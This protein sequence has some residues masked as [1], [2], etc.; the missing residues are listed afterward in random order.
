M[1]FA[2]ALVVTISLIAALASCAPSP[3]PTRDPAHQM[4]MID[5]ATVPTEF[6]GIY[7]YTRLTVNGS[8]PYLFLIDTGCTGSVVDRGVADALRLRT[9]T[10]RLGDGA[11][12]PYAV[13]V[14]LENQGLSFAPDRLDI[15]PLDSALSGALG[16]RVQ[17]ILGADF[18]A[19]RTVELDYQSG[20]V[21]ARSAAGFEASPQDA[22]LPLLMVNA[23]SPWVAVELAPPGQ[24]SFGTL[25]LVDTGFGGGLSLAAGTAR[26]FGLPGA[27]P[28]LTTRSRDVFGEHQ[29]LAFRLAGGA[30]GPFRFDGPTVTIRSAPE[31]TNPLV[32][33]S[34]IGVEVWRRFTVTFDFARCR[35]LLRPNTA[36]ADP[37]DETLTGLG[38]FWEGP[39]LDRCVVRETLEGSPAAAAGLN[40]G[41]VIIEVDGRPSSEFRA[42][43]MRRYYQSSAGRPVILRIIRDGREL[44]CTIVPARRI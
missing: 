14:Q 27:M 37:F 15:L 1:L 44:T 40:P 43:R 42:A 28:T 11:R 5:W 26:R 20:V 9:K 16:R 13:G 30:V 34:L 3:P 8:G 25:L 35:L 22:V 29:D 32:P 21:R 19:T 10:H 4:A 33:D 18:F 23:R 17:G 2:R 6:D 36:L 39:G 24:Q 31:D 12:H 41:D 7:F 38:T